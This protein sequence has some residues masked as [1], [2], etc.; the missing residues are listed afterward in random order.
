MSKSI[1]YIYQLDKCLDWIIKNNYTRVVL[2]FNSEDLKDTSK[3]VSYL[4]EA[5]KAPRNQ[6]EISNTTKSLDLYVTQA[7]TCCV[8][9]IVTQ[10]VSNV[11]A[12]IHFGQ[13]CLSKPHLAHQE[14]DNP[15]LFVLTHSRQESTI[16]NSNL[17]KIINHIESLAGANSHR[18]ICLLYDAHLVDYAQ[19]IND[20]LHDKK[21]DDCVEIAK[22]IIPTPNWS[23]TAHQSLTTEQ[24]DNPIGQHSLSKSIDC[25]KSAICLSAK[26]AINLILQLP[27][28]V[29]KIDCYTDAVIEKLDVS[30]ILNKRIALVNR[31]RDDEE[32]RFGVIITNPLPNISELVTRLGNYAKARKHILYFVSMIQTIDECKIGNFDLCDAFVVVNSCT[33]STILESLYF[34]RPIITELEFK[35]AC[36]FEAVYGRVLWPS[37]DSHLSEQDLINKRKVSDV[38]L[39]LIHSRNELLERCSSARTNLWSGLDYKKEDNVDECSVG[40]EDLAIEE[41]LHGI[42]STYRS[43]PL[44]KSS[45]ISDP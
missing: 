8:D 43:E 4:E 37:S 23:T 34:N 24:P 40:V 30:R 3:V 42:A 17:E 13:V 10:H 7:N 22:L 31:L 15:V 5:Y 33:C 29:W 11:D 18:P 16:F 28:N 27:S 21:L 26:P 1:E 36:G 35:L 6:K 38:S 44:K 19:A 14:Q 39:A 12:I 9:L 25:Y 2:Q 41:G 32:L 20:L 45:D